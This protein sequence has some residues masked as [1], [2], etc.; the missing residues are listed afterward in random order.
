MGDNLLKLVQT[1]V[2]QWLKLLPSWIAGPLLWGWVYGAPQLPQ[3]APTP[4]VSLVTPP[5]GGVYRRAPRGGL[6]PPRPRVFLEDQEW[7]SLEGVFPGEADLFEDA[8]WDYFI[9]QQD[10]TL[11][12]REDLSTG[13]VDY[14]YGTREGAYSDEDFPQAWD[15]DLFRRFEHR[16]TSYAR[17]DHPGLDEVEFF[18]PRRRYRRRRRGAPRSLHQRLATHL[19]R[20]STPGDGP[21]SF[22]RSDNPFL[23]DGYYPQWAG[24]AD[25][26]LFRSAPT[27]ITQD[28]NWP[29]TFYY[30][31]LYEHRHTW[32]GDPTGGNPSA[33]A[34][35][36]RGWSKWLFRRRSRSW[37]PLRWGV[38]LSWS[39]RP[40]YSWW[41]NPKLKRPYLPNG[42]SRGRRFRFRDLYRQRQLLWDGRTNRWGA[43]FSG[44]TA[45]ALVDPECW[46]FFENTRF[47]QASFFHRGRR[48]RDRTRKL[49]RESRWWSAPRG[50]NPRGWSRRKGF[51][52]PR[53]WIT[54]RTLGLS[55]PVRSRE[56]PWVAPSWAPAVAR[57]ARGSSDHPLPPT[58]VVPGLLLLLGWLIFWVVWQNTYTPLAWFMVYQPD[59]SPEPWGYGPFHMWG[60]KE[61]DPWQRY[62]VSGSF[63]GDYF[64]K[65]SLAL[66]NEW[67]L[68]R[69]GSPRERWSTRVFGDGA[70]ALH[71]GD[72]NWGYQPPVGHRWWSHP[73]IGANLLGLAYRKSIVPTYMFMDE[74]FQDGMWYTQNV[75]GWNGADIANQLER[76]IYFPYMDVF[77][78]SWAHLHDVIGDSWVVFRG[79]RTHVDGGQ[80]LTTFRRMIDHRYNNLR[81]ITHWLYRIIYKRMWPSTDG[82]TYWRECTASQGD[83]MQRVLYDSPEW[84]SPVG[85]YGVPQWEMAYLE[86]WE[87]V[88]STQLWASPRGTRR[89]TIGLKA[90]DQLFAL[91]TRNLVRSE[92]FIYLGVPTAWELHLNGELIR[93]WSQAP[94]AAEDPETPLNWFNSRINLILPR[95]QPWVEYLVDFFLLPVGV[96]FF[97]GAALVGSRPNRGG[98]LGVQVT[99]VER[100]N[101]LFST[102]TPGGGTSFSSRR[103]QLGRGLT[104]AQEGRYLRRWGRPPAGR[105]PARSTRE[106]ASWR[107]T[108][109]EYWSTH[110]SGFSRQSPR[111]GRRFSRGQ[112]WNSSRGGFSVS[113]GVTSFVGPATP[114]GGLG[115]HL[116]RSSS[117]RDYRVVQQARPRGG[118]LVC[119]S[120]SKGSP[121]TSYLFRGGSTFSRE[122][123]FA[124]L[125][126][127]FEVT[128]P[129]RGRRRRPRGDDRLLTPEGTRS[130]HRRPRPP[131]GDYSSEVYKPTPGAAAAALLPILEDSGIW[132][133]PPGWFTRAAQADWHRQR[134]QKTAA[135]APLVGQ[136]NFS[137]I[138]QLG[139]TE[140]GRVTF[141]G[142][143]LV[144]VTSPLPGFSTWLYDEE[145]HEHTLEGYQPDDGYQEQQADPLGEDFSGFVYLGGWTPPR[146]ERV[147]PLKNTLLSY[148][149]GQTLPMGVYGETPSGGVGDPYWGG[150][151]W[152]PLGIPHP[153]AR[154]PLWGGYEVPRLY[155]RLSRGGPTRWENLDRR[156]LR[157]R[158]RNRRRRT[159]WTTPWG[160]LSSAAALESELYGLGWSTREGLTPEVQ[161]DDIDTLEFGASSLH[162]GGSY[163]LGGVAGIIY[164]Q[165]RPV[166]LATTP[167]WSLPTGL[168]G[169]RYLVGEDL[170]YPGRPTDPE[171][172][173]FEGFT[174]GYI[175]NYEEDSEVELGQVFDRDP[176]DEHFDS[177]HFENLDAEIPRSR[178]QD[179]PVWLIEEALGGASP[180]E[181]SPEGVYSR[182]GGSNFTVPDGED[183]GFRS[184]RRELRRH[185][186]RAQIKVSRWRRRLEPTRFYRG[187]DAVNQHLREVSPGGP[188]EQALTRNETETFTNPVGDSLEE[189][190]DDE[191]ELRL[192][193]LTEIYYGDYPTGVFIDS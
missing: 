48:L 193:A 149:R 38:H 93:R 7:F 138:T 19:G 190:E 166:T 26:H 39:K 125:G 135:A 184:T 100:Y 66:P 6:L 167:V 132:R 87:K 24:W 52:N 10:D 103:P 42:F 157:R 32:G 11:T 105:R 80:E 98:V 109:E 59:W 94:P 8:G 21:T 130:A 133:V 187:A 99:P 168:N 121:E 82:L 107:W 85:V 176:D 155:R 162:G 77:I 49:R 124:T 158:R 62:T 90:L 46:G 84:V 29:E 22:N 129:A 128:Y 18:N 141:P 182:L 33:W 131:R 150:P 116:V 5:H 64:R 164:L 4:R 75:V 47:F 61:F 112:R 63:G 147:V 88:T 126:G 68:F 97:Y 192:W 108:P 92:G 140:L 95:I 102:P 142:A 57:L 160:L 3:W 120:G 171:G 177:S 101:P 144:E 139:L 55:R 153:Y 110:R 148:H 14:L 43:P 123:S 17:D 134:Y 172:I 16:E 79:F 191:L 152:G 173:L 27:R 50:V 70:Y 117:W 189:E 114:G 169:W 178:T 146:V 179:F 91:D 34:R 170:R 136:V 86:N 13:E 1:F 151:L 180:G 72:W 188:D 174:T 44:R 35:N 74:I 30:Y 76:Q 163:T 156:E 69:E 119:L 165:H 96:I 83:D 37:S 159:G 58:G 67:E 65:T 118:H 181:V 122:S 20:L 81:D 41:I 145:Y 73:G 45:N 54:Q 106:V 161:L 111:V 56:T 137:G 89:N 183:P 104:L 40:L 60:F 12:L 53:W 51:F 185:Y 9:Q 25:W 186:R 31:L 2:L 36:A 23:Y 15:I 28:F 113:G 71:W 154:N 175:D 115:Y 127:D 78:P 143:S